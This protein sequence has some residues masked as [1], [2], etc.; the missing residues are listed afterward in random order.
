MRFRAFYIFLSS[1]FSGKSLS[2]PIL[3]GPVGPD[4]RIMA[5]SRRSAFNHIKLI[6]LQQLSRNAPAHI[7][8]ELD[9]ARELL[10]D[11]A[12]NDEHAAFLAPRHSDQILFTIVY[13]VRERRP[14]VY[15]LEAIVREPGYDM[16]STDVQ[17]VVRQLVA[18]NRGFY[19]SYPL[20]TWAHGKYAKESYLEKLFCST[21]L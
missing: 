18:D 19:Q 9:V 21:K 14:N 2:P 6:Q 13:R 1:V 7:C 3:N 12:R 17:H 16:R 11:P 5:A 15:T 4:L 8:Q 20:K 10:R